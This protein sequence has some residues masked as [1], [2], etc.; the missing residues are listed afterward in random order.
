MDTISPDYIALNAE[1]HDR[2]PKYG[3]GAWCRGGHVLEI[4]MHEEYKTVLDYGCGKGALKDDIGNAVEVAEYDPAIPGKDAAPAP[5]DLVVCFDV[6]EHVEPEYLPRVLI[7]LRR[8]TSNE[9]FIIIPMSPSSQTLADGR[10]A[11]L[12]VKPSEW[13]REQFSPN[14]WRVVSWETH[15]H[16]IW[17]RLKPLYEL[18]DIKAKMAVSYAA[19]HDNVLRNIPRVADRLTQLHLVKHEE[20]DRRAVIVCFG[21]SL[22]S[23]WMQVGLDRFDPKTDIFTVS[24]AH[25]FMIERDIVPKAHIDCDPRPH[26]ITQMGVAHPD[27]EYWLA[28]CIHPDYIDHVRGGKRTALW[29]AYNGEDSCAV[30]DIEPGQRMIVGGGSVGLRSMSLLYHLGY[31]QFDI[32]GMDCS[33]RETGKQWAGEHHGKIKDEIEVTIAGRTFLTAPA[34]ICYF[35]Y[36]KKQASYMVGAEIRLHGDGML[37]HSVRVNS[38]VS[39][40][41]GSGHAELHPAGPA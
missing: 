11:H 33:F 26:K 34:L 35:R 28:S 2:D 41:H 16:E 12:I 31:R 1:L 17:A 29:H 40:D 39:G 36:F 3:T 23:T 25:K 9:L 4:M 24:A 30:L 7:D 6:L 18:G 8:V 20:N 37:Q 19:R 5:A 10:N 32:H 21:P 27:V 38:D 22:L 15:G 14:D 13:W